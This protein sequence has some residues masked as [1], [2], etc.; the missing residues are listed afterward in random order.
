MI[1]VTGGTASG[2][3]TVCSKV[4][5]RLDTP[6]VSLISMDSFYRPL[7]KEERQHVGE[8]NFDHPS[9]FDWE[10]FVKTLKKIKQ[11]KSVSIP[12]YDF[13]LHARLE[14]THKVYGADVVMVEGILTLHSAAIRDLLDIKIF[15]DADSDLRLARRIRRDIAERGRSVESVLNQYELSVKPAFDQFIFPTKAFADIIIPHSNV[16]M[17]A[18]DMLVLHV[19]SRLQQRAIDFK[20][21][22]AAAKKVISE[23][24]A[25]PFN[26]G[27]S[28]CE[29]LQELP[30]SVSIMNKSKGLVA[31]HT[32]IR[33]RHTPPDEFVYQVNRLT[34]LVVEFALSYLPFEPCTVTTPTKMSFIGS[35]F[36]SRICGVSVVRG[37]VAMEYGL[38][39]VCEDI[40]IGKIVI[41]QSSDKLAGP[42]LYY[43]KLP[44]DIADRRILLLDPV[45]GTSQTVK[46]AVRV[47]LD[48]GVLEENIVYVSLI[49]ARNGVKTLAET[50]PRLKIVSSHLDESTSDSEFTDPGLGCFGE[51]YFHMES[52][53]N[54]IPLYAGAN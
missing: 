36:A 43:T 9:A 46:M 21:E 3:T 31:I 32:I 20:S 18:I 28:A 38:R 24:S 30:H 25:S 51:R 14:S 2:K 34:R 53:I 12:I 23:R 33:D 17:V 22:A 54:E 52:S 26:F 47:L 50:F 4:L 1:G 10:L 29:D 11:G 15:V 16:N 48:H 35:K 42:R 49:V 19:R 37:G 40:R 6:W 45:L 41:Q 8:Y 7:T 39:Q 44:H 27:P 13:S 5:S